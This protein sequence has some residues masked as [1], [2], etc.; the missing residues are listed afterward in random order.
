[1]GSRAYDVAATTRN[2][3]DLWGMVIANRCGYQESLIH[4]IYFREMFQ[5]DQSLFLENLALYGILKMKI[6][7][8]M[9]GMVIP[10]LD[11]Y[12]Y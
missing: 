5:H 9:L 1:M 4:K 3:L 6:V 10:F 8:V 11:Y 2:N 7:F 12:V